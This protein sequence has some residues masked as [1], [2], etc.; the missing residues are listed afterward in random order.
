MSRNTEDYVWAIQRAFNLLRADVPIGALAKLPA[1]G[2][3][4]EEL[5]ARAVA[6]LLSVL[7]PDDVPQPSIADRLQERA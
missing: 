7:E 4:C 1:G 5:V 6:E 2:V 3:E